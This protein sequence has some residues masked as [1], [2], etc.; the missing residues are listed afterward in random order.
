MEKIKPC[1]FCGSKKV[2]V[3]RTNPD[4]C[5]IRCENC[6]A[7]A[8]SDAVRKKAIAIWNRRPKRDGFAKI[9]YDDEAI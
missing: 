7:D 9:V 6:G 3:C 8:C 4:A 2:V 5:W 1:P